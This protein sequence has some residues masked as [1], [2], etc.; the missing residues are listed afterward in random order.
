MQRCKVALLHDAGLDDM[1]YQVAK[2]FQQARKG[3]LPAAMGNGDL[4]DLLEGI[5]KDKGP[6]PLLPALDNDESW[7]L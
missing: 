1:A 3:V 6:L 5:G 2:E 4:D 7:A